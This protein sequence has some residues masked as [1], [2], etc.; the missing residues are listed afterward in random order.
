[1]ARVVILNGTSSSGKTSLARAIQRL[2]KGP[3]LRVSMDDFLEMM[4]P[5]FANDD[6]AF[7]FRLVSGAEPAEVE[8]GTGSYG[9]A[10]MRGM[11][12]SVAALADQGLDLVV[13]D[14]ML[15]AG[16]QAHYR[17]VL[18]EHRVTFIGVRCALETAEQRERDR[19]DRDIGMARWQFTRVHAGRDYDLEVST[20]DAS[21]DEGARVI[22]G[23]VGM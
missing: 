23:A 9:A 19:G 17:D 2:A 22:L 14:V 6:E 4:P 7:S 1:M 18:A 15:G 10:L 12:A 3:V 13:D 21:P 8:I 16:D 20:D 5:R 11:R